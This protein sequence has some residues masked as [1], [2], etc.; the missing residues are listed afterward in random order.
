MAQKSVES[1]LDDIRYLN[2]SHYLLVQEVRR[3][4][5][6]LFHDVE[7]EVKYG[8]ILFSSGAMFSGVFAYKEHV[9]VEF[10]EGAK[11]IDPFGFLEGSGKFRRHIKLKSTSDVIE[12]QL[13][14]Y[15]RM[16]L[17]VARAI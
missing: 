2:E 13:A 15:L 6:E 12:R 9:T 10:S 5:K 7:E 17:D 8:G 11:I 14:A 1:L 3:L 16:A 4:V